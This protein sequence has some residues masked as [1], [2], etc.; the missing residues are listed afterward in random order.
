MRGPGC[1]VM[2]DERHPKLLSLTFLYCSFSLVAG[3][4]GRNGD[5]NVG[6]KRKEVTGKG[7][8]IEKKLDLEGEKGLHH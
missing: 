8:N 1:S 6:E 5:G 2:K 3:V 7:T 4:E